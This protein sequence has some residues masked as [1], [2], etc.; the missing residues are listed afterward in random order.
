VDALIAVG[1]DGSLGI[2][3]QLHQ[4]GLRLVG[5]PKTID[6]DLDST[7]MT[8]GYTSAVS[9]ATDC[10]DRL[11]VTAQ[12]HRRV[13]VVEVM[14]RHAG[15]IALSAG[16]AGAADAILIPEI[17]YRIERVA[18]RLARRTAEGR[19]AIVVVAEGAHAAGGEVLV[20][21]REPGRAE[22]LGGVGEQVARE[23]QE[24]IGCETR[25]LSL[26]HLV[27]GGSPVALDRI[28]GLM[29]GTA[30]VRALAEGQNGVMVAVNPPRID[31]VPLEE[32]VARMKRVPLDGES[33][34]TARS[35]G[36]ALGD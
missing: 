2:A 18:E 12:A 31:Y 4:Q 22:L 15:W 3:R 9:F 23:L 11:H 25:A 13:L 33:V 35:L 36:I 30:A 1:G 21:Q 29:F 24:R 17:P 10:L 26:G 20:K 32:A 27:R 14:G 7:W 8:F 5:V 34:L 16:I 19:H 28:L 6:N